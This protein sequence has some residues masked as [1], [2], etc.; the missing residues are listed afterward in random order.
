MGKQAGNSTAPTEVENRRR[1]R[2]NNQKSPRGK[3]SQKAPPHC[4]PKSSH[5][6]YGSSLTQGAEPSEPLQANRCRRSTENTREGLLPN[7][8][9]QR[10]SRS[11]RRCQKRQK[12]RRATCGRV[13]CAKPQ[14]P[15]EEHGTRSENQAPHQRHRKPNR[16]RSTQEQDRQLEPERLRKPLT[17]TCGRTL[18]GKPQEEAQKQTPARGSKKAYPAQSRRR[19]RHSSAARERTD[20]PKQGQPGGSQRKLARSA[21]A[22]DGLSGVKADGATRQHY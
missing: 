17:V 4:H 20:T 5:N 6:P 12:L 3:G 9:H 2:Q 19:E 18:R 8:R 10:S 21:T 11:S 7:L 14:A 13:S 16:H 15:E 1:R 22:G